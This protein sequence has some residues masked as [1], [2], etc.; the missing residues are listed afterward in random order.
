MPK[1]PLRFSKHWTIV[2]DHDEYKVGQVVDVQLQNGSKMVKITDVVVRSTRE[3]KAYDL[4]F[5]VD[6]EH[7]G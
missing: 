2:A 4:L 3:G 6:V 5:T 1:R 7:Y